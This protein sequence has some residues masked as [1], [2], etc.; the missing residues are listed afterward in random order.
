MRKR[1]FEVRRRFKSRYEPSLFQRL[2]SSHQ[3][4]FTVPELR[5]AL[6]RFWRAALESE[7]L[8]KRTRKGEF[9]RAAYQR[10]RATSCERW[11]GDNAPEA[12]DP[13]SAD[14]TMPPYVNLGAADGAAR[15][16]LTLVPAGPFREG[17][18]TS[19]MLDRVR[20]A[21]EAQIDPDGWIEKPDDFEFGLTPRFDGRLDLPKIA[22]AGI[23]AM[24]EP[25]EAMIH[26][27]GDKVSADEMQWREAADVWR[28][29]IIK[30]LKE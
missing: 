9:D 17:V 30:A 19:K 22:R 8:G 25:T 15:G 7:R 1:R 6:A 12:A 16:F 13:M 27:G 18:V 14:E 24:R 21:I 4:S 10:K 26:A 5:K 29:M 20:K 11:R 23:A 2:S 28:A 3:T